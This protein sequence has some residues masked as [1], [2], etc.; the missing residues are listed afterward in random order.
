MNVLLNNLFCSYF[1]LFVDR[2][3]LGNPTLH[4]VIKTLDTSLVSARGRSRWV[5]DAN[6]LQAIAFIQTG[7][8]H[9]SEDQNEPK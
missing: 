2:H 9:T 4:V 3:G 6:E 5:S 7:L 1:G 8:S